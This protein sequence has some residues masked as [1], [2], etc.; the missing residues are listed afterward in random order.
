MVA[1]DGALPAG[2]DVRIPIV[3]SQFHNLTPPGTPIT[4]V[5]RVWF[6]D[7]GIE[8]LLAAFDA[9]RRDVDEIESAKP[10]QRAIKN[11]THKPIVLA[12]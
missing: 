2:P 5:C 4:Q 6:T 8:A 7:M 1:P 12:K 10:T 9:K 11:K 3:L